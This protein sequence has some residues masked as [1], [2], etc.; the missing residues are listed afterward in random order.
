MGLQRE[1]GYY[2]PR[3]WPRDWRRRYAVRLPLLAASSSRSSPSCPGL[4]FFSAFATPAASFADFHHW[5]DLSRCIRHPDSHSGV[6]Y[7]W[8]HSI[9]PVASQRAASHPSRLAGQATH[10]LMIIGSVLAMNLPHL[11]CRRRT[12][13]QIKYM[14][15]G[16]GTLFVRFYTSSQGLLFAMPMSGWMPSAQVACCIQPVDTTTC[17]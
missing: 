5:L 16:L 3:A 12:L 2:L 1:H 11:S 6:L 14:L 4:G 17:P 7:G 15:L 13:A 8:I 9:P 10:F